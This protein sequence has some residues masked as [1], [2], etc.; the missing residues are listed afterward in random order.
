MSDSSFSLPVVLPNNISLEMKV[1][2]VHYYPATMLSY[3]FYFVESR[4][5]I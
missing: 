1:S 3:N 2:L 5:V 4:A